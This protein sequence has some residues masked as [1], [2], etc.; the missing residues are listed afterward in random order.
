MEAR[1]GSGQSVYISRPAVVEM[2]SA[3]S[4]KV[5]AGQLS[6]AAADL[7]RSTLYVD[8]YQKANP[9]K[10]LFTQDSRCP[11]PALLSRTPLLRDV[12]VSSKRVR[13]AG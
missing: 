9:G 10:R 11:I 2:Q 13:R 1:G 3:F 4:G 5:R 7:L 6:E 8:A 12:A